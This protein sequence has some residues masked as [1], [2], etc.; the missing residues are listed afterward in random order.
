MPIY[1]FVCEECREEF[2]KFVISASYAN[3]VKC[4]KCGSEKVTKKISACAIG[5]DSGSGASCTAF[6]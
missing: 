1:E 6:G 3:Q 5:G 2:E 4:P